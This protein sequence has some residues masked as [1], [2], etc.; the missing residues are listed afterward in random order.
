MGDI[1]VKYNPDFWSSFSMPPETAFYKKNAKE[2]RSIYGVPL[3]V[4]Y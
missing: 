4:Q 3:D 1:P 2:L